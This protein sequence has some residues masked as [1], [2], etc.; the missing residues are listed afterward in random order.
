[1]NLWDAIILGLVE[2]LT[3]F[4][5]VSS[6]GHLILVSHWLGLDDDPAARHAVNAF[7]IIIQGGAILAV[8]GLFW[9]RVMQ[10]LRGLLGRD[11]AGL[12]LLIN[13]G[14]SFLP[15][16]VMGVLLNDWIEER[17]FRPAPVT[18]ALFLGGVVLI[19]LRKWQRRVY[20]DSGPGEATIDAH[21]YVDLEHLSWRRALVIGLLQ[22]LAM[23]PGTSRS[24]MTIIGGMLV[25]MR[26]RHAAEY[27]FLLGVPTLGGACAYKGYRTFFV[28]EH[29]VFEVLGAAEVLLG[30]LVA[31]ASAAI[32]VKWMIGYLNRH[33]LALFGWYRIVLAGTLAVLI[34][35]GRLKIE[36]KSATPADD[37]PALIR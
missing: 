34:L 4:L 16:A 31:A 19:L 27:S 6:T 3:E 25:G 7:N 20:H 5:P 10:M 26:P 18:L 35:D 36:P 8:L 29:S 17:L 21:A 15:A 33:G 24:M 1:M 32:A 2:G 23:W 28:D 30:A 9:P 37:A 14:L 22:C 13:L 12:R 11:G